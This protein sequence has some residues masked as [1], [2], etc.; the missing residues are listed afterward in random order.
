[1]RPTHTPMYF[2]QKAYLCHMPFKNI[3]ET[4]RNIYVVIGAEQQ[5]QNENR[6]LKK[7][8]DACNTQF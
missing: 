6:D 2:G 1:M 7:Y 5:L 3:N 8:Q 4:L